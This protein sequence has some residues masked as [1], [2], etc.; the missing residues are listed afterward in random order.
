MTVGV[1]VGVTVVGS[2]CSNRPQL[3][4][5]RGITVIVLDGESEASRINV[6]EGC[7]YEVSICLT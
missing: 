7:R 5:N 1:T 6:L 4:V 2:R 3:L